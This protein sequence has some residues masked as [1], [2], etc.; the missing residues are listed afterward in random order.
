VIALL[1]ARLDADP[2]IATLRAQAASAGEAAL[3]NL[4]AQWRSTVLR[5][6]VATSKTPGDDQCRSG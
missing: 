5:Q 2:A 1:L 3:R 6:L 4:A